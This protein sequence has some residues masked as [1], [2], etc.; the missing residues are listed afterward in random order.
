MVTRTAYAADAPG[1]LSEIG[2]GFV[3]FVPNPLP[4][5]MVWTGELVAA[6]SLADQALGQLAGVG[7]TLPNPHLLI[8]PF[9]QKEAVLSSRIEGTRA[10]LSDL[11]LFDLETASEPEMA[12]AREVRNYVL[13]L[14]RGLERIADLPIG[15]RLLCELHQVLLDGVRGTGGAGELRRLQVH[16]GPTRRMNDA[17]FI[18]PPANEIPRLL[19]ELEHFIHEEKSLPPLIRF[20]LTHYQFEAIHPFHDGNGR[21][22]RLLISLLLCAE[23]LMPQPLLYLSAYFERN[24]AEYY[25]TLREI[26]T[27]GHWNQWLTYFLEGVRQQSYDAIAT[28]NGLA[29]LREDFHERLHA[30][31]A[32]GLLHKLVDGLFE[33]PAITVP[34]AASLLGVTYRSAQQN[35]ERLVGAGVLREMTGQK[36][37]RIFICDA[38]IEAIEGANHQED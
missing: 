29:A 38:I 34:G 8:R 23:G 24:R 37:N 25:R 2:G 26:S 33:T 35:V 22:G 5:P 11:L 14:E 28:A 18:P 36:R 1:T 10:S 6:L 30:P 7:R 12:D 19:G 17:T 13:A 21:I 15:T 31:R 16:I 20:A 27:H 4:P 9:L 32:T 3:A